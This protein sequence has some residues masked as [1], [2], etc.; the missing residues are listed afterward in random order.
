MKHF[1]GFSSNVT[2]RIYD[3][4]SNLRCPTL[5]D[6]RWYK[7]VF[8]SRVMMKEECKNALWKE[9]FINGLPNLFAHMIHT[10]LSNKIGIIEY[11]SLIYGDIISIISKIG[12]KMCIDIKISK[13]LNKEKRKRKYEIGNFCE[14][15]Y[16]L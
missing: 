7:D 16:P 1:I 3:Q 6:F 11:D 8:M 5:S 9:K 2:S 15:Y 14:K 4:L 12:L 13:N 10:D